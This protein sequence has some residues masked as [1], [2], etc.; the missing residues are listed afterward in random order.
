MYAGLTI[1]L[2]TSHFV[3]VSEMLSCH[4]FHVK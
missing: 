4:V 1:I 2:Q 3:F